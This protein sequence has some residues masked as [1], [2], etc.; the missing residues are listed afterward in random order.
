MAACEFPGVKQAR[1]LCLEYHSE[2]A[3]AGVQ[4]EGDYH[5]PINPPCL[6]QSAELRAKHATHVQFSTFSNE[7]CLEILSVVIN[8]PLLP[9]LGVQRMAYKRCSR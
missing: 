7:Q 3:S 4:R 9:C 6:P 5:H 1:S 2:R 8:V